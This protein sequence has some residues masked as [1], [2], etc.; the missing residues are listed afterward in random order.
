MRTLSLSPGWRRNLHRVSG[1]MV[2]VSAIALADEPPSISFLEFL[3]QEESEGWMEPMLDEEQIA[4]TEIKQ[5]SN[6]EESNET[7]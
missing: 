2:L 5:M 1:G 6:G 4:T 3:A 7:D